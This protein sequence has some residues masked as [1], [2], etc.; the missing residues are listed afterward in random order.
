VFRA[1]GGR[2]YQ[3][4]ED[5]AGRPLEPQDDCF[6]VLAPSEFVFSSS[7][8]PSRPPLC[9]AVHSS[10]SAGHLLQVVLS[11][12][13]VVLYLTFVPIYSRSVDYVSVASPTP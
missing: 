3:E 11:F 10:I 4:G 13:S 7:V 5:S 9:Y 2:R 6:V 8:R 12:R 1:V